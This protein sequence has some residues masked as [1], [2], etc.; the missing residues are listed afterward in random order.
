M[1]RLEDEFISPTVVET[2][3]FVRCIR[4]KPCI[5]NGQKG[6]GRLV[7]GVFMTREHSL[8]DRHTVVARHTD[9]VTR[10]VGHRDA[11][12]DLGLFAQLKP[13]LVKRRAQR[14]HEI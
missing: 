3:F 2:V 7:W 5:P 9:T 12:K 8:V 4:A 13:T 10:R 6:V 11:V 14:I 1:Y